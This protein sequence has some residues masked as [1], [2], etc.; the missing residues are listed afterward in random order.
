VCPFFIT[1]VFSFELVRVTTIDQLTI[2]ED[3]DLFFQQI[4]SND[5]AIMSTLK[6]KLQ[7]YRWL[8]V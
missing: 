5:D 4:V 8:A 7:L 3:D 1:R 6:N 2:I